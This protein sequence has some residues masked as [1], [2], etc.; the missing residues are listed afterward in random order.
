M[1]GRMDK[2]R[3]ATYIGPPRRITGGNPA[4]TPFGALLAP[5]SQPGCWDAQFDSRTVL[6]DGKPLGWN[7]HAFPKKHFKI[8][9]D[10]LM[11]EQQNG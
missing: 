6:R 7:W 8:D 5:C 11:E 4:G 2:Y 3:H 10:E 1:K 9:E